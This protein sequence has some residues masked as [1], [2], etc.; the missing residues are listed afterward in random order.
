MNQ[1][2][3]PIL[4]MLMACKGD[5]ATSTC[6]AMCDWAVTCASV[7]RAVDTEALRTECLAATAATDAGCANA[8]AGKLDPATRKALDTCTNAI[9]ERAAATECDGFIGSI[10]ALKTA[11][12]PP[13]CVA[14]G[15]DIQATFTAAQAS[16]AESSDALCDRFTETF[17]VRIDECLIA[18][19]GTIPQVVVDELGTPVA[20]CVERLAFQ[21]EGCKSDVLYQPEESLS[22]VN[23]ARQAARECL[24]SLA[25]LACDPLLQ[26]EV[27][28]LCAGAFASTDDTLAFG[29]ALLSVVTDVATAVEAAQ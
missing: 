19:L 1:T 7:E 29:Q 4:A 18:D 5:P 25:E 28:N 27:P 14:T 20:L 10:D 12:A 8:E 17:C 22:D 24:A 6:E 11:T 2:V 21:T 23:T 13:E 9:A 16:V 15:P 3:I 26:G